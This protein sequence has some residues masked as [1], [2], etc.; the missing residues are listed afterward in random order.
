MNK[1]KY[2]GLPDDLRAVLDANS[3]Q[4]A[5]HHGRHAPWDDRRPGS[6]AMAKKR[7]NPRSSCCP[8]TR[9]RRWQQ[10]DRTGEIDAWMKA[11][12]GNAELL[13]QTQGADR[14]V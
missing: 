13:A 11:Q 2:E 8:R 1:P 3:G 10:A 9:R 7:G 4:P 12:P 14:Q 5:A 6:Q